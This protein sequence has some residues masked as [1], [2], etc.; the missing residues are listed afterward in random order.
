MTCY[1]IIFTKILLPERVHNC[2][3]LSLTYPLLII[4][5]H[6]DQLKKGPTDHQFELDLYLTLY[7]NPCD[8]H[9]LRS[10]F[11]KYLS[12]WYRHWYQNASI[13]CDDPAFLHPYTGFRFPQCRAE[14]L[15]NLIGL[16]RSQQLKSLLSPGP[17]FRV[18]VFYLPPNKC[19][20]GNKDWI[21]GYPNVYWPYTV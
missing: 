5:E 4:L 17:M 14:L 8:Y 10:H 18:R 7:Y 6:K 15:L 20:N 19:W 3:F 11:L 21:K 16:C 9:V 1:C 13:H 2:I 12:W